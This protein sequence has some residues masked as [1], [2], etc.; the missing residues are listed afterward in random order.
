[1]AAARGSS[2][3]RKLMW[4]NMLVSG[5]ALLLACAAF[6]AYDQISFP[7][8][9]L[10]KLSVQAQIIGSSSGAPLEA[11]DPRAAQNTL[12]AL[13]PSTHVVAAGIDRLDG[14]P[15][16]AYWRDRVPHALAL[17]PIPPGRVEAHW[18]KN[19]RMVLAR[20]IL[21]GGKPVGVAYI[22]SDLGELSARLGEDAKLA[23]LVLLVS[24]LAAPLASWMFRR[25]VARPI[26]HLAEI[27]R[28]V[29][30]ER[31]CSLR[32]TPTGKR[33]E[34]GLL[35][36]AFNEMLEQIQERDAALQQAHNELEQHVAE[37]AA[38]LTAANEELEAFS[39][40]VSHDLRAPLRGIDGFSQAL[41]EDCA[42][43]LDEQGKSHLHRIR[44]ATQRMGLLI[45]DLLNLSRVTR[46]EIRKERVDLTA[47]ARSIA[48]ELQRNQPDRRVEFRIE[49]GLA[50][51]AD[52]R[53]LRIALVNLLGNAWKFTSK[54]P[55]AWIEFGSSR[56]NGAS[57]YFVRDNG[58]GFDP[59]FADR[60]FGAFRR[61]HAMQEFP[62]T[63]VGL[64]I[65][66][67]IIHR[68]GGRVWA[69]GAVAQGATFY[70]TL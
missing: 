26:V 23:S 28:V 63:G 11:N 36:A 69:E 65:V 2:I 34:I 70:F 54:R 30:R 18:M 40:S 60:L 51:R 45:D 31:D 42:E 44:A 62:G 66:Q 7:K 6:V 16:A 9:I 27:A 59:A 58:A 29:T 43:R 48:T 53:L 24:L 67:R 39:Y 35:I 20:S 33:D 21:V 56:A 14:E 17:P 57:A 46:S 52:P 32:A 13:E 41:L 25:A 8:I 10:H 47:M 61:L 55:A 12:A 37:R 3:S 68:H 64:A 49:D 22:E 15:F 1:M 4:M 50:S 5:S 19:G 38:Q